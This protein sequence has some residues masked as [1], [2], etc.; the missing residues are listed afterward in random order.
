MTELDGLECVDCGR[1]M[2]GLP[3]RITDGLCRDCRKHND[4]DTDVE[5]E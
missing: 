3:I 2:S 4:S 5:K 1:Q